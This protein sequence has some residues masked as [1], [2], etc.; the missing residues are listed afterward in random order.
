MIQEV[1]LPELELHR[2]PAPEGSDGRSARRQISPVSRHPTTSCN[3][4]Q[5]CFLQQRSTAGNAAHKFQLR[6]RHCC[7]NLCGVALNRLK[8]GLTSIP[9]TKHRNWQAFQR[10]TAQVNALLLA[11]SVLLEHLDPQLVL[12]SVSHR[13][14]NL[15]QCPVPAQ[16]IVFRGKA[17]DSLHHLQQ[18]YP[19]ELLLHTLCKLEL[20]WKFM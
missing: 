9:P 3:F 18:G 10:W 11:S 2:R 12:L 7:M 13:F 16:Q 20:L 6:Q 8:Q 1:V 14:Q 19:F 17:T 5:A 4:G 15:I